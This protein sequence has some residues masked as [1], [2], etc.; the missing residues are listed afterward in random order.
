MRGSFGS[1]TSGKGC[2]E[3]GRRLLFG[4]AGGILRVKAKKVAVFWG[5]VLQ[6][7]KKWLP[8]HP[9]SGKLDARSCKV[10]K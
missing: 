8:L 4:V 5:G 3:W 10:E 2:F 7:R 9:R 1:V 6:V